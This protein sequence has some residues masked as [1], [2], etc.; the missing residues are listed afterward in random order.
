VASSA[1][2]RLLTPD[3]ANSR[4]Q[5]ISRSEEEQLWKRLG[6]VW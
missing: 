3:G 1:L 4:N 2:N 6:E 5:Y